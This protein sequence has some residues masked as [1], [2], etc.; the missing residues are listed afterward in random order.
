MDYI[1][2]VDSVVEDR[3]ILKD[4]FNNPIFKELSKKLAPGGKLPPQ[5][6]ERLAKLLST[7]DARPYDFDGTLEA[8]L[9]RIALWGRITIR[10]KDPEDAINKTLS[11]NEFLDYVDDKVV[12]EERGLWV[13]EEVEINKIRFYR[14]FWSHSIGDVTEEIVVNIDLRSDLKTALKK[15]RKK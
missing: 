9:L 13:V 15:I 8:W 14:K 11:T 7:P 10:R 4:I 1:K 5:E 6:E 12:N 3:N 2:L